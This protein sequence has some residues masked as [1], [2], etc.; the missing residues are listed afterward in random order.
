MMLFR[1]GDPFLEHTFFYH[2]HRLDHRHN[3]SPYYYPIYLSSFSSSDC[4]SSSAS[5]LVDKVMM[6]ALNAIR[7]PLA[8]FIPQIGL[9]TLVG[10][11]LTPRV[12][13]DFAVFLQ[14]VVFVVFNK[15]CTSQVRRILNSPYRHS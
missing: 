5:G 7:S 8:S 13:L 6:I 4:P 2:L 14:T 3:F 12:G 1:W 11:Y 9:V 10:F 15:V